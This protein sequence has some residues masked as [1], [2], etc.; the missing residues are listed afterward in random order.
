MSILFEFR[1]ILGS[2]DL[3]VAISMHMYLLFLL[4]IINVNKIMFLL[5]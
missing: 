2:D 1:H 3:N 4:N 5:L